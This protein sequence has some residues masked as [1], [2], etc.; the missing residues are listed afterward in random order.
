VQVS[1]VRTPADKKPGSLL[2][3]TP[4]SVAMEVKVIADIIHIPVLTEPVNIIQYSCI[5]RN[6]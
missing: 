1:D 6:C 2:A 3:L 4:L 5:I